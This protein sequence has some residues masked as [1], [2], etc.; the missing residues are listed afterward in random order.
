MLVFIITSHG[1]N[2]TLHLTVKGGHSWMR[3]RPANFKHTKR[4]IPQ[5]CVQSF[6]LIR[7]FLSIKN[8]LE[9]VGILNEVI[10]MIVLIIPSHNCR[11][12]TENKPNL[13]V[14]AINVSRYQLE[15]GCQ[16]H[17]LEFII[18]TLVRDYLPSEVGCL[19]Q[20][21]P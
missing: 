11:N 12:L 21:R 13:T 16:N 6:Q 17:F 19:V 20:N 3:T 8:L 10:A 2:A 14:G 1:V 5:R 7:E 9:L 4:R 15:N 18:R